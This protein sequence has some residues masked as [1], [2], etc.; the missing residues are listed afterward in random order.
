MLKVMG[1]RMDKYNSAERRDYTVH[2]LILVAAGLIIL[3]GITIVVPLYETSVAVIIAIGVLIGIGVAIV[4][5]GQALERERDVSDLNEIFFA[6]MPLGMNIWN[7][8]YKLISTSK[9][10][11]ELFGAQSKEE[12]LE[13]FFEFSPPTQ[14]CGTPSPEK[15][16]GY[17]KQAFT[18]GRA[19][20]EWMYQNSKGEPISAELVLV[21]FAHK[22]KNYVVVYIFDMRSLREQEET[23]RMM[24]ESC[25]M[26]IE[27]WDDSLQLVECS[28]KA[29]EFFGLTGKNE[30]IERYDELV[31]KYQPCGTPTMS[32]AKDLLRLA[33]SEGYAHSE[34]VHIHPLT[35]EVLNVEITLVRIRRGGR[36]FVVG[37]NHD[38]RPLRNAMDKMQEAGNMARILLETSPLLIEVY[39][40]NF[41]VIDCNQQTLDM[42]GLTYKEEYIQRYDEFTPEFQPCGTP[43]KEMIEAHNRLVLEIGFLRHEWMHRLP[44]GQPLPVEATC[45]CVEQDGRRLIVGYS[46]DLRNIKSALTEV[47]KAD[48]RAALMLNA[49]PLSCFMARPVFAGVGEV[50]VEAIDFNNAA[51]ELF[52]FA[53][54]EDAFNRFYDI[55]EKA[56]DEA[57][58]SKIPIDDAAAA[59][60]KGR[61]DFEY[62]H[63]RLDG[64]LIPCNVTLVSVNYM[65]EKVLACYQQDLRPIKAA[66]D[67]VRETAEESNKA[68]SRFLARMSHEIRTPISAVLGISEIQL[69]NPD[70]SPVIEESFAKIFDSSNVLLSIVN[71][72]L[73]LSKIEAEKMDLAHKEYE[74]ASLISDTVQ[75]HI[76]F[77][78]DKDLDFTLNVDENLP[79]ALIGDDLRIKQIINNLLSNSFKYTESGYVN[80][81]LKYGPCEAFDAAEMRLVIEVSDTGLGMTPQQISTLYNEYMR[82]HE[83]EKQSVGGTGLGMPIVHSLV[84][85]MDASIDVESEVGIGTKVTVCIPQKIAE[86][87]VLG[88]EMAD[89]LERFEITANSANKRFRFTPEPMPYGRV[90]VVDDISANLYVASGLLAFYSLGVE[91]CES[92]FTAIEKIKSGNVYDIVFMDQMMP[93]I[94][95]TET[96]RVLRD[97]GYNEPIVALT[98]NAL[99]GQAEEFI[100]NGFDGFI[101][102]PI[103]TVHLNTILLKYIKDKQ[104][105]DVL[106]AA[107]TL[108][109]TAGNIDTF[110]NDAELLDRLRKDFVRDQKNTAS[111]IRQYLANGDKETAHRLAHTLKSLAKLIHEEELAKIAELVESLISAGKVPD[112]TMI[113][114]LEQ[115]LDCAVKRHSAGHKITNPGTQQTFD[116]DKAAEVLGRLKPLLE[117]RS[118]ASADVLGELAALP[119]AAVLA[120][121][122][123]TFNFPAALKTLITLQDVYDEM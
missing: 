46:H 15:A 62:M 26:F 20:A 25:P 120:R 7:D 48:E 40:E 97:M 44:N 59:L 34:W 60:E 116:K 73:D 111:D 91:T 61:V 4:K 38:L 27:L 1:W 100:N 88:R 45:V 80:L 78:N 110:Q 32:K 112:N 6:N 89:N 16:R 109:R 23:N 113:S 64:E 123:K 18:D 119:E 106:Q 41:N 54:K 66:L 10:S 53:D 105:E 5:V 50:D 87:E 82:F 33:F 101:S 58:R 84:K 95:G 29:N 39:D 122:I 36:D 11:L 117:Q 14:P 99:I 28:Q 98:A 90:L 86:A 67:K 3:V 31:P 118:S 17:V 19:K 65:G 43:S 51:I 93:G 115:E 121:Q 9:Q 37:Y 68:K 63:R 102:K 81:S 57:P 70:L 74:V 72:I 114:H 77:I 69:Q 22:G 13:R 107:A 75:P 21:R 8:E 56:E 49:T 47:R 108:E 24:L 96:M 71:D 94:N 2:L 76:V 92:G 30:Y 55:F 103:Q 52:G 79:K 85:M 104:P 83:N 35:G 12:Y 42:F